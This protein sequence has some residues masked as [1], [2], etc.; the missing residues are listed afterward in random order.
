M[1]EEEL[2]AENVH[3]HR[4]WTLDELLASDNRFAP[5]ALPSLIQD[6]LLHGP[7]TTPTRLGL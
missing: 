5:R 1:T 7:P 6:L 2:R 3:G 4:W